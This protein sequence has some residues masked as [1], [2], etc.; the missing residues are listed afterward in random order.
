MAVAVRWVTVR[1]LTICIGGLRRRKALAQRRRRQRRRG[2]RRGNTGAALEV[3]AFDPRGVARG[4][5]RIGRLLAR[6]AQSGQR[7]GRFFGRAAGRGIDF[8]I[9][10]ARAIERGGDRAFQRVAGR[11]SRSSGD[12][13]RPH[14]G[15]HGAAGLFELVLD[16][17]DRE[18]QRFGA[19]RRFARE[20]IEGLQPAGEIFAGARHR[21]EPVLQRAV[22]ATNLVAGLARGRDHHLGLARDR[23]AHRADL[24]AQLAGQCFQ[25]L[26][27]C[28]QPGRKIA[29]IVG[30]RVGNRFQPLALVA[31]FVGHGFHRRQRMR[32]G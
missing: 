26:T 13:A 6:F 14:G 9:R 3:L 15:V 11:G 32:H 17:R 18:G 4:A 12:F 30:R 27:L 10:L 20:A 22:G 24:A 7:P 21:A 2:F 16:P 25:R 23:L 8:G 1:A 28:G 19:R 29:G 5:Q 31:D